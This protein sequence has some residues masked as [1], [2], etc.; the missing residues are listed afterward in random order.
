MRHLV[1]RERA[2]L[3]QIA[4]DRPVGLAVLAGVADPDQRAV[5]EADLARA[6]DLQEELGDRVVDP[7]QLEAAPGQR[8]GVDLARA[9]SRARTCRP[10]TRPSIA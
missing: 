6:L 2:D 10:S 1:R 3:D 9:S 5:V 8:A 4:A 7:E